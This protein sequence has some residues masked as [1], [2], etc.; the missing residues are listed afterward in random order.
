MQ[1]GF[2]N[3]KSNSATSKTSEKTNIYD[4]ISNDSKMTAKKTKDSNT[5]YSTGGSTSSTSNGPAPSAANAS[6]KSVPASTK[7][8]NVNSAERPKALD[9]FV[10][11]Y[12]IL[13][14]DLNANEEQIKKAY[15]VM[16]LKLHPDKQR[17]LPEDKKAH[18]EAFTQ[19]KDAYDVLIDADRK[20][21]YD[22][23]GVDFGEQSPDKMIW[24][25]GWN[26]CCAPL[27]LFFIKALVLGFLNWALGWYYIW[28][29]ALMGCGGLLGY[30]I[31]QH[32]V[33]PEA[34]YKAALKA[35]CGM[36]CAVVVVLVLMSV[37]EV[38]PDTIII[39]GLVMH[40]VWPLLMEAA[41]YLKVAGVGIFVLSTFFAWWYN[42]GYWYLYM[43]VFWLGIAILLGLIVGA[44]CIHFL[45][46]S[47]DTNGC[48]DKVKKHREEITRC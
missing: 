19:L 36:V 39:F 21:T 34:D 15:K 25:V 23:F 3:K 46:D 10:D 38:I 29:L 42:G 31:K 40:S 8:T 1:N 33:T 27:G 20:K 37:S 2:F 48:R 44:I 13:N 24:S 22:R 30:C 14:I 47:M 5:R 35:A 26:M 16:S 12:D 11:Y 28:W 7:A 43:N 32:Q 4:N 9:I 45:S 18:P 6:K 17:N 41:Q